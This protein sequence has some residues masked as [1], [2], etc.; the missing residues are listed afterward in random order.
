LIYLEADFPHQ[1]Q[2]SSQGAYPVVRTE[3]GKLE[4]CEGLGLLLSFAVVVDVDV[5]ELLLAVVSQESSLDFAFGV[6][7]TFVNC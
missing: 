7:L 2:A 4:L 3:P 6:L 1:E 5:L